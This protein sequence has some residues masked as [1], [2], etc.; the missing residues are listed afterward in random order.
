MSKAH[1]RQRV[2]SDALRLIN[3]DFNL[4]APANERNASLDVPR[5]SS[6]GHQRMSSDISNLTSS[7]SLSS[8]TRK[9]PPKPINTQNTPQI[10]VTGHSDAPSS[11]SHHRSRSSAYLSPRLAAQTFD[12]HQNQHLQMHNHKDGFHHTPLS[13]RPEEMTPIEKSH[14]VPPVNFPPV[15]PTWSNMPCK[16]QLAIL[17]LSRF[18]DFFQMASLQTYMVHQLK[19]FNPDLSDAVISH[20]AGVLQGS[21]TAAQI[22]T[23]ILWGRLADRPTMGRKFVLSIGLVGT[24]ISMLGVGFSTTYTQA[25]VW[26]IMGGAINGT[27]G[28]ARTMVAETVDK[29]W[30]P[31]AFLLLPA[32]FNVANVAGPI[33]SGLLVEPVNSFPGLFGPKSTFGGADGVLW[34]KAY[35]YALANMLSTI[36]LFAEA[37][38]VSYFLKET[39]RGYKGAEWG[40]WSFTIV[41]KTVVDGFKGASS[42][43]VKAVTESRM[44]NRRLL[45]SRENTSIELDR[46][47]GDPDEKI[48]FKRPPARLP[49]RKI[50]TT[51]VLWTLLSIAIFDFHMG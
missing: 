46:V 18:V 14:N 27:V 21:F 32:A 31:R 24:G 13:P 39:L 8:A 25:V 19:S 48:Q 29:R 44:L 16:P 33:L 20:Q 2:N 45:S 51:N 3:D 50:F 41:V 35:P 11:T 1:L 37:I 15:Q 38:L 4:S 23:S 22:F 26:R 42:R 5:P 36:L 49:F 30:H 47:D 28:A 10:T 9:Q 12:Q 43:G 7:P 6:A 34:M 40:A 17:C